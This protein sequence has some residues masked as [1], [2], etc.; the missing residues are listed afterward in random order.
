MSEENARVVVDVLDLEAAAD[1]L[2]GWGFVLEAVFPADDPRAMQLR[3]WGM[4]LELRRATTASALRLRIPSDAAV[5]AEPPT[6]FGRLEIQPER[7]APQPEAAIPAGEP[8]LVV[9]RQHADAPG[10]V[11][12]AGMHYRDLLPGRQGGR[13]IASLIEVPAGGPVP[14][15]VH[16]H[17]V[18]FQSI[19]CAR[20]WVRVIYEGQ[21]ESF[22]LEAGDAVIQPP[23]IRHRVLECSPGLQVLEIGC[24]AEHITRVE[25]ELSLPSAP[26]PPDHRFSWGPWSQT[27]VRHRAQQAAWTPAASLPGFVEQDWGFAS[28][29]G[30]LA[31]QRSLR[32]ERP[33]LA[34]GQRLPAADEFNFLFVREG[35]L[36]LAG[37]TLGGEQATLG[38]GDALTWTT[39]DQIELREVEVGTEFV[40]CRLP[41]H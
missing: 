15:Y 39:R 20:G 38:A 34:R 22:V 3:G 12:R 41:A 33:D 24:P 29:T 25:H 28:A 18:R 11:G 8:A 10:G 35:G 2:R 30:G 27:F 13:F 7:P 19:Y 1:W 26:L 4:A 37:P 40:W 16:F 31:D 5:D 36:K 6:H 14:D 21:G 23:T 9:S 17:E 32:C